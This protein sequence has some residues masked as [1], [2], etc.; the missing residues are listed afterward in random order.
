[1]AT[2]YFLCEINGFF[3]DR[4]NEDIEQYGVVIDEQDHLSEDSLNV[5]TTIINKCEERSR[6]SSRERM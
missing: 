1:M 4:F 5:T 6:S 2:G 3:K